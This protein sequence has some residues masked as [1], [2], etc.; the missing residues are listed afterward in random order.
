VER[1]TARAEGNPFYIEE[2]LNYLQDRGADPRDLRSL[3]QIELP[4]SLHSLILSRIDQLSERQV[5]TLKVASVIGRLFR[6]A[7][8]WGAYPQ[9]GD[10]GQILFDLENLSRIDLMAPE[11]AEPELTYLFKHIITQEVTYESLP[12][13][14]R[15]AL[16]EQIGGFIETSFPTA[17]DQYVDLLAFHFERGQ[18]DEKKRKYLVQA[19]QAAQAN[20]ANIA[21]IDYYRR[22]LPLLSAAERGAVLLKLGQ[23]LELVGQWGEAGEIYRQALELAEQSGDCLVQVVQDCHRRACCANRAA[24]T[25]AA[26]LAAAAQGLR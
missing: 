4:T 22:A 15:A 21:A 25:K 9:L 26:C 8:L 13:A 20:Y 12:Y 16:H 6:A 7:M 3:E 23:V 5:I 17:I 14:T 11:P 19:G 2:L 24:T 10:H 18:N 1:I